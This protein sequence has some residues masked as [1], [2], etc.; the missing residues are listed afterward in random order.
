MLDE[1]YIG[2]YD[3]R[4]PT[5]PHVMH[6]E[7][8]FC[9][10]FSILDIFLVFQNNTSNFLFQIHSASTKHREDNSVFLKEFINQLF[11]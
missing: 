6:R 1:N 7:G 3:Y 5:H 2:S 9:I 8:S 4:L 11:S 10:K